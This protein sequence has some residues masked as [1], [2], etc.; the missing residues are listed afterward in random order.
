MLNAIMLNGEGRVSKDNPV[1]SWY[2]E[3]CYLTANFAGYQMR[4]VTEDGR[5]DLKYLH[6]QSLGYN[7]VEDAKAAAPEFAKAVLLKMLSSISQI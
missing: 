2:G 3:E 4:I 6:Y 7:S 5:S 1:Q